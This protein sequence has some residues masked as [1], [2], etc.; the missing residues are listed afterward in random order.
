ML[1]LVGMMRGIAVGMTYLSDMG[2]IHRDLAARNILVDENFVCKL[3]DFGM[4]RIL[5]DDSEAAY[6][7]TVSVL[8][9]AADGHNLRVITF[10]NVK[11]KYLYFVSGRKDTNTLDS[12]RSYCLWKI[13][14]S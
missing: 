11:R 13:F 4:S 7:A 10:R 12:P 9:V 6:T 3:S 14:L 2:Y 8:T 1:Q 5:E